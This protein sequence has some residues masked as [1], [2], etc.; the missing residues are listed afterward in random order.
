[1]AVLNPYD[2]DGYDAIKDARIEGRPT[3]GKPKTP[4]SAWDRLLG[5]DQVSRYKPDWD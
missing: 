5:T 4:Y 2:D 3:H 1:M